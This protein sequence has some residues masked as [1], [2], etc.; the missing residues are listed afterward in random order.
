MK[1]VIAFGMA[2][3]CICTFAGCGAEPAPEAPNTMVP[4]VQVDGELYLTTGLESTEADPAGEFDGQITSTVSGSERPAKDNQSNFGEGFAYRLGETEGTLEVCID[5]KWWVYATED[6]RDK[7][8][9]AGRYLMLEEPPA[10]VVTMGEESIEAHRGDMDWHTAASD[11][12]SLMQSAQGAAGVAWPTLHIG[13]SLT[14]SL[15][16]VAKPD[17]VS[18][19]YRN[20]DD[21]PIEGE[22]EF[23]PVKT[24]NEAGDCYLVD[25]Q[26]ENCTYEVVAV[27]QNAETYGGEVHYHFQ[28]EK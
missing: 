2:L 22:G 14:A 8:M 6:V 15:Y 7:I 9:N 27:W 3:I 11:E 19:C 13:E 16:W 24:G 17:Q 20:K 21:Q 5:G 12:M 26:A 23:I 25:L 18:I 1:K 28:T 10:M 4:M